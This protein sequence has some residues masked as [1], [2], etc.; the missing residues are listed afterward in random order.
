MESHA[1][2]SGMN[3][4]FGLVDFLVA[5]VSLFILFNAVAEVAALSIWKS[6]GAFAAVMLALS[7]PAFL[8]LQAV[9][10]MP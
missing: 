1:L 7:I 4:F 3:G 2:L 8:L 9:V 6:I 5:I 10:P